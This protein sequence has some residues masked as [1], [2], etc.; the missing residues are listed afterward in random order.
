MTRLWHG[1][2]AMGAVDGNE[3]VVTRGEGARVWDSAGR[4]YLD[5]SAGLW[6]VSVGH[7]RAEIAEAAAAQMREAR[8]PPLLLRPRERAGDRARRPDRRV[9]AV[10]RRRGVLRLRRVR[11]RRHGLQARPPLLER[12]GQGSED[13]HH[14]APARVPRH[15]R[16]RHLAGRHPGQHGG[17]R[18][19]DP[20]DAPRQLGSAGGARGAAR[21]LRR[22]RRG[23]HRRAGD[24]RGRR[25]RGARGVLDRDPPD[26]H[27]SATSCSSRTR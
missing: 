24:R 8:R 26:L 1:F 18:R 15:E 9:L 25:D 7:G 22:P 6:F 17:L 21:P 11:G 12:A 14:L 2:A 5:A 3:F 16:L 19:D 27:A 13:D 4:E 20:R 10:R 23:V